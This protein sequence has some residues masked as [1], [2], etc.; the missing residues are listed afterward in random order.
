MADIVVTA[1]YAS[2]VEDDEEGL[3]FVGFAQGE[4]EDE[5]Y[6]LFRQP[7]D[8]GPVW[9]EVNDE[10]FGAADALESVTPG[11]QGLEITLARPASYGWARSVLVQ[12]GPECEDADEALAALAGMLGAV[13]RG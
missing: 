2:V 4:A 7:L 3:L 11:P 9:F 5:D 1:A 13:W 8:G 6:A 12:I 10:A